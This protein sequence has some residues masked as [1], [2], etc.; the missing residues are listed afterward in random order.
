MAKNFEVENIEKLDIHEYAYLTPNMID[1]QFNALVLDI[2]D[3]GQLEPVK[4]C[5]GKIYD[6]RHRMKALSLLGSKTIKIDTDDTLS[7]EDIRSQVR[8]L[9]NRR[10]QTPTQL[11][12]MA[13]KEYMLLSKDKETKENQGVVASRFGISRSNLAEVKSLAERAPDIV[14]FL[15]NGQ[16]FNIGTV[17]N[18]SFTNNV[19]AINAFIREERT[20]RISEPKEFELTI[21]ENEYINKIA[22]D[23]LL[24]YGKDTVLDIAKRLYFVCS[25]E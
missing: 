10:H 21:E 5:R 24:K 19:R 16:K 14:D 25:K 18:P 8:S 2:K 17:T 3:N 6:G 1:D 22:N 11:A 7:E 15:F 23:M 9:E 20:S 4:V 13:Y 12:I